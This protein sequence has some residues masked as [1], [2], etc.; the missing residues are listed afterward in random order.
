MHIKVVL[1]YGVKTVQ[2]KTKGIK[3]HTK[4]RN[5]AGYGKVNSGNLKYVFRAGKS[6]AITLPSG[7]N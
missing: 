2:K 6:K 3:S 4:S 7:N 1:D 5:T